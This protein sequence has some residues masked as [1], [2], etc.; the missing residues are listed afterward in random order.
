MCRERNRQIEVAVPIY[1]SNYCDSNCKICNMRNSNIHFKRKSLSSEEILEQLSIIRNIERISSLLILSGE[2]NPGRDRKRLIETVYFTICHAFQMGYKKIGLNIGSLSNEEM[3]FLYDSIPVD[4]HA[5]L[6]LSVFQESYDRSIYEHYFGKLNL[7]VPKSDFDFRLSSCERWI[8]FGFTR[9][10][11]GILLGLG[12]LETSIEGLIKHC[13]IL[14][15]LGGQVEISL[16]RVIGDFDYG[17]VEKLSDDCFIEVVKYISKSCRNAKLIL[18]TR[19][20]EDMLLK[21]LDYID[22]ISPGTSDIG[23]YTKTGMILNST[24]SSQFSSAERR[25]RPSW[26]LDYVISNSNLQEIKY[27]G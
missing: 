24:N 2:L 15:A 10:N 21:L 1:I 19:E 17:K 18:T 4:L 23:G 26:V 6:G 25:K 8:K 7:N 11:I 14:E 16:P 5:N 20:S 3:I 22:I 12:N 27:Y 13:N 9:V